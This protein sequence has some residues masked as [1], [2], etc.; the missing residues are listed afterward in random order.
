VCGLKPL[1][2]L[3]FESKLDA[4]QGVERLKAAGLDTKMTR[5][6]LN[7]LGK[8]WWHVEACQPIRVRDI[9]DLEL[10]KLDYA[11]AFPAAANEISAEVEHFADRRLKSFFGR[12]WD[13]EDCPLWLTGLILGYPVE[14]SISLK[15]G[16]VA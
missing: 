16:W 7:G 14:N 8:H 11:D 1:G 4:T 12:R 5:G 9:G 2:E 3:T 10:L 13:A 15:A 6:H